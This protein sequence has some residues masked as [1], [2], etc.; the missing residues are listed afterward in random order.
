[1]TSKKHLTEGRWR[2]NMETWLRAV[3][4]VR[5]QEMADR[6]L[7]EPELLLKQFEQRLTFS[8]NATPPRR[9]IVMLMIQSILPVSAHG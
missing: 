4:S 1:M 5:R 8:T 6:L 9:Y 7:L 2:K 3:R